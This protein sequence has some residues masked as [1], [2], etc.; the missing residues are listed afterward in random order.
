MSS[1]SS[2]SITHSSPHSVR[3]DEDLF[4]LL[5]CMLLSSGADSKSH[6]LKYQEHQDLFELDFK[7]K[8]NEHSMFLFCQI[9]S[10]ALHG[11]I[12]SYAV[13]YVL[14]QFEYIPILPKNNIPPDI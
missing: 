5:G 9:I 4:H 3:N 11:P 10:V 14:D 2:F 12:N 7:I 1:V 13:V 6:G 8:L